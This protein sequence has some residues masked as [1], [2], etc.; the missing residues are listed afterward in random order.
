MSEIQ[1]QIKKGLI[2]E[3]GRPKGPVP[4]NFGLIVFPG[5]ASLDA[6]G[7]IDALTVISMTF[8]LKLSIIAETLDPVS[9]KFAEQTLV[10]S[11]F[12]QS[13]VPTHTFASP[14]PLDVLI[15]PGGMGA[16]HPGIQSAIDFVAGIYPSLKYL[17]TVCN[18]AGIAAR[19]GVLDGKRATTN[20]M[21]WWSET[22]QR[23]Q[24]RWVPHARWVFDGNVWSSSGVS[25]GLDAILAFIEGVYGEEAAERVSDVLEYERHKDSNWDPYAVK[26]GLPSNE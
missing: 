3:E 8:P 17:V 26:Y 9:T 10:G 12:G 24:V 4:V 5:F 16:K 18:G 11:D 13:I 21:A 22:A 23:T 20:K 2:S 6:F 25:A 19:G 1:E 15:V 14:P 7:P